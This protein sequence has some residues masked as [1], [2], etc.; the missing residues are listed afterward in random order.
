[1]FKYFKIFIFLFALILSSSA[2]AKPVP[3]GAGDGDVAANILFLVDSSA[4]M[5]RW[6]GGD[7]LGKA[8][9]V[10]YD[11]DGRILITQNLRRARYGL[12]RYLAN[13]T[14]DTSFPGGGLSRVPSTGCSHSNAAITSG[15]GANARILKSATVKFLEGLSST[16]SI[17]GTS[18]TDENVIIVNSRDRRQGTQRFVF[19]LS[20][21]LS[22][23]LFVLS[24]NEIGSPINYDFDVK[25]IGGTPYIFMTFVQGGRRGSQ[26]S[27][28]S[29][30]LETME[31][32]E[33]NINDR[34]DILRNHTRISV[35]NEGTIAYINDSRTGD[36]VG[37][38]LT[39]SGPAFALGAETRRCTAV[40]SPILTSQVMWATGVEVSPDN[41]NI[42]L[43]YTSPSPRD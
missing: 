39:P 28:K 22:R 43:L 10:T 27:F 15:W 29:C 26:G 40:N 23:C 36:V 33:T 20:E 2:N 17:N 37:H 34:N 8:R 3:P 18:F 42:C 31:C 41:S 35:N 6:I 25:T 38:A 13:G 32:E 12:V 14:R 9:G 5:G 4:S 1:M 11:A 19:G 30:N 21:D 7:G 24:S 16:D